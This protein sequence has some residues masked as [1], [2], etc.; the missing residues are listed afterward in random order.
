MRKT[1]LLEVCNSLPV[2]VC[3]V[4]RDRHVLYA[5]RALTALAELTEPAGSTTSSIGAT[6]GC[7]HALDDPRGCGFGRRCVECAVRLAVEDTFA[8]GQEHRDVERQL[9]LERD[10]VRRDVAILASTA[11]VQ[12]DGHDALMVSLQDVT[13]RRNE[14]ER[15]RSFY[16][17]SAIG[18]YRTTPAGEILQANRALVHMLG[19][20]SFEELAE[21][22]LLGKGAN[23][24]YP[25]AKFV[26]RIER[27]G[28]VSGFESFWI[29]ADGSRRWLQ[30]NAWLT[31]DR[32]GRPL[33]YDGTVD[34]VTRLKEEQIR[35]RHLYEDQQTITEITGMLA[36]ITVENA[37]VQLDRVMKTIGENLGADRVHIAAESRMFQWCAPGVPP[38]QD[39]SGSQATEEWVRL[40]D[41]IGQ[42][43][44]VQIPDVPALSSVPRDTRS[45]C[46]LTFPKNEN[47]L[48]GGLGLETIRAHREWDAREVGLL[49]VIN[50]VLMTSFVALKA[51]RRLREGEQKLRM[52]LDNVTDVVWSLSYPDFEPLF[53]SPSAEALYG[54][55]TDVFYNNPDYWQELVHPDDRHTTGA[56]L[57]DLEAQGHAERVCRIIRPDGEVRW[58]RDS[59]HFVR[60]PEG[61]PVAVTGVASDVTERKNAQIELERTAWALRERIK[62]RDALVAVSNAFQEG[63]PLTD[64]LSHVSKVI[65]A[66]FAYPEI[67]CARVTFEGNEYVSPGFSESPWMLSEDIHVEGETAGKVTVYCAEETHATDDDPFLPEEKALVQEIAGRIGIMV[68]RARILETLQLQAA[69]IRNAGVS[70]IICNALDPDTP[71]LYVNESF[72]RLTGYTAAEVLGRNPRFLYHD[73]SDQPGID[74]IRAAIREGRESSALLRNFRKDGTPFWCEMRT[75]PVRNST[76]VVTHFVGVSSDVTDMLD[77]KQELLE[78]EERLRALFRSVPVMAVQGYKMDGETVF[79]NEAAE[80]LYGYT[81]EE[82]L[83]RNL[84]DLIIPPEMRASVRQAMD[85]MARTGE[86]IPASELSLMR[87]NGSRVSVFSGHVV[88]RSPNADPILFCIDFDLTERKRHE[89]EILRQQQF[90]KVLAGSAAGFVSLGPDKLDAA[91]LGVLQQIGE[92]FGAERSSI[93]LL[94]PDGATG[95]HT[96]EW[97]REGKKSIKDSSRHYS[98]QKAPWF[99]EL[100]IDRRVTVHIPDVEQLPPEASYEQAFLKRLGIQA[101]L[102]VPLIGSGGVRGLL[103]LDLEQPY[104]W[105][106]TQ[107]DGLGI[108]AKVIADYLD[109]LDDYQELMR[110]KSESDTAREEAEK[111]NRAKSE[112]LSSM[113]HELRTPLNAILGFSQLLCHEEDLNTRQR[114]FAEEVVAAANHLLSL[115]NEVLDLSRI[116]QGRVDLSIETVSCA[117]VVS[118]SV[119]MIR[120]FAEKHGIQLEIGDAQVL[121]MKADAVRVKQVLANLLSNAVKYNKAGGSVVVA[122]SRRG[123][124]VRISVTDTG[125]G[126]PEEKMGELFT[127]FN[128]LGREGG[129]IEGVGIGL[130][131]SK[132]LIELMGGS[133][134]VQSV[135][136]EG[137]TFWIELAASE[138]PVEDV[139]HETALETALETVVRSPDSANAEK[140]I[141]VLYIED[142]PAAI[143]L[144]ERILST[145]ERYRLITAH[146]GLLGVEI[147]EMDHPDIML[148]DINLPGIDGYEIVQRVRKTP[149]GRDIPVIALSANAMEQAVKRGED[150]GFTAYVTKPFDVAAFLVTL[151]ELASGRQQN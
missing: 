111:A 12:F 61:N 95:T 126:I 81:E 133:I 68:E 78:N 90:Q 127:H 37:S 76:G 60:D 67:T 1:D 62:E 34:D 63:H 11:I 132:R 123:D 18:I 121:P 122:C 56:A 128:R 107:I 148:V 45:L 47:E 136:G 109:R 151:E 49:R 27:D 21:R 48:A 36:G 130:A 42:D 19:Y 88:V 66:G 82:A 86:A 89:S 64:T 2:A 46:Y 40:M 119:K 142:N 38:W 39:G 83:G 99:K 96:H 41:R 10:G 135:A 30:E 146:T 16:E 139:S 79:W 93:V 59:S 137:S 57:S 15:Y 110:L 70:I 6:F 115:V 31:R 20:E 24:D 8:T 73:D 149:W 118:E 4:D 7:I 100:L 51:S 145:R 33:Y 28:Y 129:A 120:P 143:R 113:S 147:A 85:A 114:D 138:E 116:E 71:I 53:I 17:N 43:E 44:L 69:A 3:V 108:I 5:N 9:T 144:M 106:E 91:I 92:F 150:E 75:A 140:P 105:A 77:M 13:N 23:P 94:S 25:R 58:I 97:V 101:S 112:F 131:H 26:E 72:E 14:E 102:I 103:G 124:G 84:N 35:Y 87:K 117:D 74:T 50:K 141:T 22:D 98:L 80:K 54:L 55:P 125:E 134:G 29:R 52:V 104:T 32:E 65:P